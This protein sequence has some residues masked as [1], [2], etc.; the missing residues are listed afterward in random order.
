MIFGHRSLSTQVGQHLALT[1]TDLGFV[2]ILDS[3]GEQIARVPLPPGIAV[4]EA[5]VV[6]ERAR[7]K[8][9]A[10]DRERTFAELS[11]EPF[12]EGDLD[13]RIASIPARRLAPPIDR[14]S[15][16]LGGRLW[17][18]LFR[19][20]AQWE[21]WQVWDIAGAEPVLEFVLTLPTGE[22]FLDAAGDRV[23]LRQRDETDVSYLVLREIE[24]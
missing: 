19:P 5:D 24:G 4:T 7:R 8:A 12:T 1:Q 15:G 6:A 23:L 17:L 10:E 21:Q 20:G 14:M 11:G 18:R 9:R 2:Q 13:E 16:D 3:S 22:E